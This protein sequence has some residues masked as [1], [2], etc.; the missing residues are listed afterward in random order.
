MNFDD[1]DMTHFLEG[2]TIVVA[3]GG[4]AGSAFAAGI[5]KQWNP[6]L[7]PPKIIIFERDS[8]DV[9]TQ[10]EGYSLSLMGTD[11]TGGLAA[12]KKLD[13]LDQ[14]LTKAVSGLDGQ[15]YFKIWGPDWKE[16]ARFR[17]KAL[18]GIRA[19]SIRIAR[20]ELRHVLHSAADVDSMIQWESRCI[21]TTRRENGRIAVQV[22][23]GADGHLLEQECDLLIAADG[24]SSK[25]RTYLRPDDTLEYTGAVLRGGL[26]RFEEALPEPL[27]RDWGFMLS[28]TG[29]SCFFSPVDDHSVVWALGHLESDQVP[30]LDSSSAVAIQAV[31]DQSLHLGSA[32]Q[33]PFRTIVA[34][35]D[36]Q[37]T[38]CLNAKDKM[39]FHH[40]ASNLSAMP[41]V[42]IGDSNHALSPF[43]GYGA[44]LAL[45]DGWDL[46]EQLCR[47]GSL[48]EAVAAYDDESVPR[49]TR[50]VQGARK[51]L[52]MG[53]ST[54]WRYWIFCFMLLVARLVSILLGKR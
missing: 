31:M 38:M 13:L 25:L 42:F 46:A 7:K 24:A 6:A 28:G 14:T 22:L 51:R 37:T 36:P 50:V 2:K 32:F 26:S 23:Q 3:G 44:N 40:D 20:K 45:C 47:G 12:L 9:A 10:R 4:V 52:K 15:G 16:Y 1:G 39:P 11:E 35:T 21:S 27:C 54:G 53:H 34:C 19:P 29:V 33:E 49:A 41:V 17:R 8:E 18:P 5:R 30:A 48:Q 43:A